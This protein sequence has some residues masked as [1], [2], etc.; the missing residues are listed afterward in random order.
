MKRLFFLLLLAVTFA[1][2]CSVKIC[3]DGGRDTIEVKNCGWKIFGLWAIA[4]GNPEEPNNECCLLF[5]DSL[6][7]DVN[8]MLL[9]D[10][11]KKHG[12][13]AFKNIHTFTTRE[14]ALFLFTRQTYRTSAELIK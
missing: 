1:G 12:Y 4:S 3:K 9:D 11:M 2:C 13:S 6:F 8:M 7:L 5:T 10:A 14:N